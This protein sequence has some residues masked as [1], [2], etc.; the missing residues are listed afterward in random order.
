MIIASDSVSARVAY[1]RRMPSQIT[2]RANRIYGALGGH[3]A[4]YA[5][6]AEIFEI[7]F[8]RFFRGE[9]DLRVDFRSS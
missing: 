4:S 6:A 7:G 8:N 9:A 2:M 3:I 1:Y 5:S